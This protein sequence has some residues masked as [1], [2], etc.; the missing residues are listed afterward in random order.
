[1]QLQLQL[2]WTTLQLQLQ[3]QP[4][5]LKYHYTTTTTAL[6]LQLQ[7]KHITPHYIQQLWVRWPL[8]PLQKAQIQPRF[9]RSVDSLCH[10]CI[11]MTHLSYSFLSLKL[12]PPPCAVLLVFTV[13]EHFWNKHLSEHSE[14]KGFSLLWCAHMVSSCYFR[15]FRFYTSM[16]FSRFAMH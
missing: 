4:L 16:S 8:Q 6:Q 7:T 9:G 10:P 13:C 1:M 5:Q 12:P 14:P 11:T 15:H 3:V 2:H